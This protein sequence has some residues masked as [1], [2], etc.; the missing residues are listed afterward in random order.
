MRKWPLLLITAGAVA[1]CVPAMTQPAPSAVLSGLSITG[2]TS[3]TDAIVLIGGMTGGGMTGGGMTGGG[4]TG[5]G[6]T[7][8]GMTGGGMTSGGMTSGGMTSGGMTSGMTGGGMTGTGVSPGYGA[9][10]GYAAGSQQP[11]DASDPSG[12]A[13][14]A[15]SY[16][17]L[18]HSGHCT[19]DAATGPLRRGSACHCLFGGQG[20]IQ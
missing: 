4:M 9:A 15:K 12:G 18:T 7:G 5:G 19:V 6:M 20:K 14:S 8:G 13:Q 3:S 17:C 1:V 16:I 10:T 2:S 11:Y